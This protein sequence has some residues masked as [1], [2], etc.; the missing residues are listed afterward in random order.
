MI[1]FLYILIA[2]IYIEVGAFT[3]HIFSLEF[4][5]VMVDRAFPHHCAN[6]PSY[7]ITPSYYKVVVFIVPLQGLYAILFGDTV[8]CLSPPTT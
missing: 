2:V 1:H 6:R 7:K 3:I 4:A 8:D 5:A